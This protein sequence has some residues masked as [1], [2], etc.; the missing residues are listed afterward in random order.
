MRIYSVL[1]SKTLPY[2]SLWSSLLCNL[3][4]IQEKNYLLFYMYLLH[5]RISHNLCK[6]S[7]TQIRL[8]QHRFKAPWGSK[9]QSEKKSKDRAFKPVCCRSLWNCRVTFTKSTQCPQNPY[10]R[11]H[12]V[13]ILKCHYHHLEICTPLQKPCQ[14]PN[15]RLV[16]EVLNPALGQTGL[17]R[18][19]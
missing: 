18:L 5:C 8:I 13:I 9:L 11:I 14:C 12:G 19:K 7:H 10:T 15:I 4:P 16:V 6:Y 3:L 2:F 17:R 1:T